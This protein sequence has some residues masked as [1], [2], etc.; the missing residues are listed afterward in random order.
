[1]KLLV[2]F[3]LF[4]SSLYANK[5]IYLSYDKVPQRVI[6]GEIFPITLKSLSTVRDFKNIQ[7][8][9]SN[10]SGVEILTRSPQRVKKGKYFYD[11]FQLIS[12]KTRAKLPDINAT[13]I[14]TQEYNSTLISGEKLNVI[15]LNPKKNFSNII[16]NNFELLEYKTTSYDKLHNIIIFVATAQNS[17]MNAIKFENVYKQGIESINKSFADAKVTYYVVIDKTIENFTFSYFNLLKNSYQTLTMPI[18]VDEDSVTTQSDLK[19][20]DQSRERLKMSIAAGISLLALVF[21]LFRKKYIYLVFLIIPVIYIVYLAIPD[22]ELCIKEG[23]QI[24]L[25]PVENGTIFET[26]SSKQRLLKEGKVQNFI[27]VKLKNERIGWIKNE[28]ICSF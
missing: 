19:P 13:L 18:I 16:A 4:L 7:Y 1:M 10:Y 28:D 9:F 21:I 5:V 6:Q 22:Q 11:T 24:R 17:D 2:L 8:D 14:A 27:K 23:T 20:K 26:T 15:T 3:F 25:L 12:T